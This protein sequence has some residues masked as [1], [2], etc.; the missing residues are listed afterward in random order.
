MSQVNTNS[1]Y[2]ASGGSNAVLYGVAAPANS[3]GFR[4][5]IINGAMVIDQRNAGASV[6]ITSTNAS[7][8]VLDRWFLRA[9]SATGSKVSVQRSSTAPAGFINSQ[10]I[11]SLSAYT[12]GSTE[13]FGTMQS[14]EGLNV[15]DFAW[16]TASAQSITLSFQVRSSL[17]GTFGGFVT[18][19]SGNRVYVFSYTINSAN[20]FET[21][22]VTIP[23]D[24]SGTWLTDNNAGITISFSVGAGSSTT[25]AA[26]SWGSTLYRSVT[27]QTSLVGTNG[28][29][30]YIT[31][32]QLEAGS[33]ASPFE[34]RDYGRELQMCQRYCVVYGRDQVY[35]EVG[36]TGFAVATTKVTV[37]VT[38]PVQLRVTPT[39]LSSGN[40][41]VSDAIAATAV[42]TIGVN[43]TQSSTLVVSIEATVASGLTQFRPYR[44]ESANSTTAYVAITAEL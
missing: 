7:Q 5:R 32:V 3:M 11:T 29:T 25:G 39:I 23:G 16:G 36:G 37:P 31:G 9:A 33:V 35:N 27:G 14:I 13:H 17:T 41:Q 40:F 2:D 19:D 10:L 34:R 26:G 28:A 42:S 15:A 43:T 4:N 8:Y 24:Q 6:T 30:F 20:T 38:V 44:I 18:N 12:I 1:I 22:T 21:K